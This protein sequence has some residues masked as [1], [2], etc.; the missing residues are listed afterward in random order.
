MLSWS[1]NSISISSMVCSYILKLLNGFM[2]QLKPADCECRVNAAARLHAKFT[3]MTQEDTTRRGLALGV[4]S[5]GWDVEALHRSL[6][7]AHTHKCLLEGCMTSFP[8]WTE[9]NVSESN[10]SEDLRSWGRLE[11]EGDKH[12]HRGG[13]VH[14][15]RTSYEL[16]YHCV[17]YFSWIDG[18]SLHKYSKTLLETFEGLDQQQV[19]GS[20]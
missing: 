17:S 10:S 13:S 9:T 19:Q 15:L 18:N 11:S 20:M 1:S 2:F 4:G 16:P 12:W 7:Q 5:S 8:C 14:T 3:A 6:K